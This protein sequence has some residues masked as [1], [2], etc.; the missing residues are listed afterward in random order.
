M[1]A[2]DEISG[3]SRR[4]QCEPEHRIERW[5]TSIERRKEIYR[6]LRPTDGGLMGDVNEKRENRN[7]ATI[8]ASF[9]DSRLPSHYVYDKETILYC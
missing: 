9:Q 2:R 8:I 1:E 3:T 6:P 4:T 5:K 7:R